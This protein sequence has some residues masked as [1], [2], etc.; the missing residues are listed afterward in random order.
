LIQSENDALEKMEKHIQMVARRVWRHYSHPNGTVEWREST[1]CF[2]YVAC[3]ASL[4][5]PPFLKRFLDTYPPE[6][7]PQDPR[8]YSQLLIESM[9]SWIAKNRKQTVDVP[10]FG[11]IVKPG[12]LRM[13]CYD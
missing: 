9:D 6:Q 8:V 10:A 12:S 11:T 7:I 2:S 3:R 1:H 5:R 4:W 13:T